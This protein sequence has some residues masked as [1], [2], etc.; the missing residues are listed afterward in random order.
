VLA[1]Q[2]LHALRQTL[3]DS[4][5]RASLMTESALGSVVRGTA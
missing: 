5:Q 1:P 4:E 3:A 2:Q